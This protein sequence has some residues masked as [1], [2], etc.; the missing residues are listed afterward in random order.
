MPKTTQRGSVVKSELPDTLKRSDEKAQR[1]FA[2]AHDSALE[3][4]GSESRAH[5]VAY[6]ALKHGYEK[7][8][9]HWEAKKEG[10]GP[11]DERAEHGGPD[12]T[13][14]TASGVDAKASKRHLLEVAGRLSIR[15]RWKMTKHELI[16]A[17]RR[18]NRRA[19]RAHR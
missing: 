12:A 9:D 10:R 17:I 13:G 16:S 14:A 2:K 7:V 11:S 8:G 15:G 19:D 6:D 18:A 1:T 4:Y 3:Q 5:R